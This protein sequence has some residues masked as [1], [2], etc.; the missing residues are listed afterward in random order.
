MS[1]TANPAKLASAA[2]TNAAEF[3][4][5]LKR[6]DEARWL[7]SRYAPQADREL[8]V[9]IYLLN[10]ELQRALG[11]KEPMLGKIRLQWWR[12]TMDQVAGE[13]PLRR[14]DLSEELARVTKA[15]P[16]LIAP[17]ITL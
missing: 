17:I 7:A 1:D 10:Q 13:A 5:R 12:E 8:L 15:R 14:H 3:D 4:A 9:A 16:D 2:L 6:T 11:S